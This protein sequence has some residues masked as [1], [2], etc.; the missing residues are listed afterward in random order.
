MKLDCR[1][2]K[3]AARKRERM[4]TDP[5]FALA[6]QLS[7]QKW[8]A[9]NPDYWK[10]YRRKNPEK[11]E[12]NRQLQII[13]NWQRKPKSKEKTAAD[14]AVIAKVAA[15]MSYKFSPIGQY[16]LVPVIAKVAP[17]KIRIYEI[18]APYQ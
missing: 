2:A 9:S 7:N 13:R 1:R 18:S 6:C 3:K 15:S 5:D 17:L 11:A 8:A 14:T 10:N 16:Y 12:R 4:R